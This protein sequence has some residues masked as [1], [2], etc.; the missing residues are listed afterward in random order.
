MSLMEPVY[1]ATNGNEEV[2]IVKVPE[3]VFDDDRRG[4]WIDGGDSGVEDG[5]KIGRHR[6]M[7]QFREM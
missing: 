5:F 2:G 1:N 7:V 3:M 6:V 4:I